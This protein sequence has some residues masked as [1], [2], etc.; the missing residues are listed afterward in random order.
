MP[1]P[2]CWWTCEKSKICAVLSG[3]ATVDFP[4]VAVG[5]GSAYEKF[6]NRASGYTICGIAADVMLA[7]D[8]AVRE[9]RVAVAGATRHAKRL[10]EVEVALKGKQP[11]A[12]TIAAA[13]R[14]GEEQ[15]FISDLAAS[16]E[17]RAHLTKV[18]TERALNHGVVLLKVH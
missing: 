3:V 2:R 14:I 7:S 8:S 17:Y 10:S 4:A 18:L 12:E 16:A 1:R 13:C 6:K 15:N 9:C 5:T 11:T